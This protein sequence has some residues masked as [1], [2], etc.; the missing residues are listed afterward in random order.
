VEGRGVN[1]MV[2][3]GLVLAGPSTARA[4]QDHGLSPLRGS[5]AGGVSPEFSE[6]NLCELVGARN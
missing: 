1:R 5:S 4:S 2:L 6:N 3:A